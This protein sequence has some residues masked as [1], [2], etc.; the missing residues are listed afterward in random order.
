MKFLRPERSL[1]W[2]NALVSQFWTFSLSRWT[3]GHFSIIELRRGLPSFR[4]IGCLKSGHCEDF[5]VGVFGEAGIYV[6][7]SYPSFAPAL[8]PTLS[9]SS[10]AIFTR[11][12][13]FSSFSLY[14]WLS[15]KA[16][17]FL[18]WSISPYRPLL[19]PSSLFIRLYFLNLLKSALL[20]FCSLRLSSLFIF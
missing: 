15:R 5:C 2:V 1:S 14:S 13:V 10:K 11:R 18:S 9:F 12:L 17:L 7:I 3:I 8:K 6:Y 20:L 4:G 16:T 19:L